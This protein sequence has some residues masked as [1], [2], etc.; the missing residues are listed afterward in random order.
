MKNLLTLQIVSLAL[1]IA[2]VICTIN[3]GTRTEPVRDTNVIQ[4][5]QTS[6]NSSPKS[7]PW[8]ETPAGPAAR[9]TPS[10]NYEDTYKEDRTDR[11]NSAEDGASKSG[12]TEGS[13][14]EGASGEVR[15]PGA[16]DHG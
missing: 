10:V 8:S 11:F 14:A 12:S 13:G 1:M 6:T 3:R 2:P 15:S 4:L 7:G 5:V 16:G 9:S